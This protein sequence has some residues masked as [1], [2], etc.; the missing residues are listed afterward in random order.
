MCV[1]GGGHGF[2]GEPAELEGG[3]MFQSE[4]TLHVCV[5]VYCVC[6]CNRYSCGYSRSGH[7]ASSTVLLAT[8]NVQHVH[9]MLAINIVK[10]QGFC[11]IVLHFFSDVTVYRRDTEC[12]YLRP[13]VNIC[14]GTAP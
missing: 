12:V 14:P 1:L 9:V 7:S 4:C 5:C 2:S 6:R 3:S 13:H 11:W 10:C 8:A